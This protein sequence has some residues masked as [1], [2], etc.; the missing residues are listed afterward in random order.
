MTIPQRLRDI[1][2][3]LR[4]PRDGRPWGADD[5]AADLLDAIAAELEAP[6]ADAQKVVILWRDHLPDGRYDPNAKNE[7]LI[8]QYDHIAA[9]AALQARINELEARQVPEGWVAVPIQMTPEQMRA[10]QMKS[11]IGSHIASNWSDAYSCLQE[12]WAVAL[13]AIKPGK[14]P[15]D[16]QQDTSKEQP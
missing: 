1:A 13:A 12:F 8:R 5:G 11:E 6:A 4:K 14:K 10:V 9:V 2:F 15:A 16:P 7:P 3:R